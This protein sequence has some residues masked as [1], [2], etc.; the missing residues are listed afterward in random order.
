MTAP[1]R[2]GMIGAGAMGRQ[3]AGRLR[4]EAG[5]EL[6]AIAD[7]FSRALA[8]EENVPWFADHRQLLEEVKPEAVIVVNPNHLHVSTTLDCMAAGVPVLLEKPVACSVEE[9]RE[10]LDAVRNSTVPVLV[11]HHRRH[12][13]IVARTREL[14]EQGALGQLTAVTGLWQTC[15]PD[16]Y[17][18]V[19]WHCKKG[20]G[21][22]L[23]NLVHDLD[24]M[25]YL[26]GEVVA[27]QAFTSNARRGLEVED[28]ASITLRFA[29]G[30]LGTLLGSDTVAAPW[31]WDQSTAE[32]AL[33]AQHSDQPCYLMAG[34]GGSLAVPQ[35]RLW[36]FPEGQKGW[37]I[38]LQEQDKAVEKGDP[39]VRQ[40]HHFVRVARGEEAPIVSVEDALRT[41]AVLDAV[42]RAAETGTTQQPS[43]L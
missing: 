1:L 24:L 10:L 12:N 32:V 14:L 15:K 7:P 39:Q 38:P 11:G 43:Y 20:A 31:G 30:A 36:N 6:V 40:L 5:V 19:E 35:M 21:V 25:R 8:D 33:Y 9:G 27:V 26:C 22:I 18:D 4:Q 41:M 28:T 17:Y 16:S 23:I 42:Q 13:P 34:T 2:I 29:N 37:N 3:H